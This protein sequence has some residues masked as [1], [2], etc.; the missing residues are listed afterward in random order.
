MVPTD[1]ADA[2]AQARSLGVGLTLAHQHL[3]QLSAGMRSAVMANA[4]SRVV[5]QTSPEDSKI[6]AT[7]TALD[8]EDFRSLPAFEAYV[9]LVASDA[10]Q[11]W[12]SLRTAPAPAASSNPDVVRRLSRER[13]GVSPTQV[14]AEIQRLRSGGREGDL[15]PKQ[16]IGDER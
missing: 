11:P 3:G 10:V 14:D 8:A 6:L 2:L 5:F 4:R 9:Q 13:Y 1:L 16:R 7:D 12:L 15:T